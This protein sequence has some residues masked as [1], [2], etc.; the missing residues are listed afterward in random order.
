MNAPFS[1]G[2]WVEVIDEQGRRVEI[3]YQRFLRL[4]KRRQA[5]ADRAL[6]IERSQIPAKFFNIPEHRDS[7]KFMRLASAIEKIPYSVPVRFETQEARVWMRCVQLYW[8]AKAIALAARLYP[9]SMPDPLAEGGFIQTYLLPPPA[10]HNLRLDVDADES[11]YELLVAGEPYVRQWAEE[12][13][14]DYP[15]ATAEDLF[16]ETL[17]IGFEISLTQAILR[18]IPLKWPEKKHRDHY[19]RWLKFLN[20]KF[21]EM[22]AEAEFEAALMEMSWKG[23]ALTA[24]RPLK[25]QGS[26][27]R[28]WKRYF[29]AHR[30]LNNFL[31]TAIN[32]EDEVPYSSA[33][34][35]SGRRTRKQTKIQSEV[36]ED[37]HFI[38]FREEGVQ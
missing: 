31:G 8:N 35:P 34:S 3:P 5:E 2:G 29:K 20:D 38:W 24:L 25:A 22:P 16:I 10:L 17:K 37:G 1:D 11:W 14:H 19:R 9:L 7:A 15:F 6:G 26:F 36:T 30:P 32:W 23:Y 18:P 28:L 13:G 21:N 4:Q 33:V 27:A 12:R